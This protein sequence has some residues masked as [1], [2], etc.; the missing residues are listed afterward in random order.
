MARRKTTLS[1][2]VDLLRAVKIAAAREDKPEYQVV[3][4]AL[5]AHLG[6]DVFERVWE[7]LGDGMDEDEALALAYREL[8][9]ERKARTKQRA[10]RG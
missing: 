7:R 4:D 2:D 6:L 10:R 5:R 3:E 1:I 8:K 9:A